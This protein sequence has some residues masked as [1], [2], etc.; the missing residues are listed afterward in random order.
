MA[1]PAG[2]ESTGRARKPHGKKQFNAALSEQLVLDFNAA[3][4]EH[5]RDMLLED[6]IFRFL[7]KARPNSPSVLQFRD[8]RKAKPF[9]DEPTH[10]FE[11][12]TTAEP[13]TIIDQR[14]ALQRVRQ[15]AVEIVEIS[16]GALMRKPPKKA[17]SPP[18][19]KEEKKEV[20]S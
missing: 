20:V 5:G 12:E 7:E 19:T 3:A 18:D 17:E 13:D 15:L 8:R 1:R 16:T 4:T 2:R 10:Q 14:Q 11:D 9:A 6:V